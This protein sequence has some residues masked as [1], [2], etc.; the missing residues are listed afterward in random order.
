MLYKQAF[1]ASEGF[2]V[3]TLGANNKKGRTCEAMK[4]WQRG[5]LPWFKSWLP[6]FL[7]MISYSA[8]LSLTFLILKIKTVGF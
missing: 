4:E 3:C 1:A 8:F 7:A 6:H 5:R 2:G